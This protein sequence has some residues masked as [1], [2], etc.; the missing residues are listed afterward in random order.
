[1]A[2]SCISSE[3][4]RDIGR[5]RDFFMPLAFDAPVRAVPSNYCDTVC[6]EELKW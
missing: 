4:K 6:Y 2:L 5:N 3:I 1:M